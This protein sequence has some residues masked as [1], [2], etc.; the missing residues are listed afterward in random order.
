MSGF[1]ASAPPLRVAEEVRAA[2]D[3]RGPVV[4]LE[5][6]LITHGFE[7]PKNL[8]AATAAEAAVRGRGA[9]PA[10]ICVRGGELL[11][12]LTAEELAQLADAQGAQKASRGTLAA[13]LQGGG[14]AGTTVSATMVAAYLCGIRLFATGGIG[15]VHRGGAQSLDI[16]AD[17][18]ELART[19]TLV[20][21][22]GPKS[23]L[24]VDLT[25]EY[26]ETRGVPVVG[27]QTRQLAGFYS[28]DSGRTLPTS[29]ADA[30]DAARLATTHWSLGLAT[31]VVVAVPVPH[32][33]ALA[34]DET[35]LAIAT[36]IADADAARVHG[37]AATPFVLG[38]VAEL[39]SGR[40]VA[41]NLALI[42]NNAGVAADIATALARRAE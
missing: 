11:V 1:R 40:S 42:E 7:H 15:G 23:M 32:A 17:L 21:C 24:D 33:A 9:V 8:E 37:P 6:T 27:W 3:E 36:A 13:A 20:V 18:D 10:T 41:A 14:W 38:R 4:A 16:S 12:G 30:D 28:R 2:L 34:R 25:L 29:V 22:A 39:T 35:D 5:S 19:P 26:L 31:A